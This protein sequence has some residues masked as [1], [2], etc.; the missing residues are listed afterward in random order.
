MKQGSKPRPERSWVEICCFGC[1]CLQLFWPRVVM[2]KLLNINPRDSDYSA[3]TDDG[4]DIGSD[5]ETEEFF[6]CG[7]GIGSR[8]RGIREEDPQPDLNDC[9]PRLRRRNSETFRAQY[10]STKELRFVA[11]TIFSPFLINRICVGTWNVGG[12]VPPDDLDIDDWID[13]DEPADIYVFGF[14][15]IVPLN[16]GNIF[17]AEDNRPVP[18]WENIIRETLDRIQPAN[19]KVKCYSDPSSPTKFKP[20]DDVP[21]LEEEII[22]ESESDIGE[23]IYPLDEDPNGFDEV[24]NSSGKNSVLRS[25]GVS[26]FNDVVELDAPLEQGLQR[27]ISSSKSLNGLN[28]L[29]MEDFYEDAGD[30][31]RLQN[32]KFTRT[33]S[34][35]AENRKLTRMLSGT[36]R[37]GLSWPEPPLNFLPQNVLERP[38]SFKPRKS[39]RAIKSFKTYNSFKSINDMCHMVSAIALL[40]E[41]DLES[42]M[43][44]KRR[45]S[46]V[47]IVSKQ[48]V[49]IFLTIW[50]RR[51]LRRHIQNLKVSTVGVGVMGYIGNKGSISVSMSIYQTL[52]CFICTHLTSG[53]KD[54]DELKRNAD[55]HEI[56][57]RTRFHSLSAIGLPK[58]IHDHER[59]IWM[60]DLNY[61]INLPYDKVRDLISKEEWSKLIERD[62][63]VGEL[64][65]GHSFDGWSEGA[66][67]FAPTYK[68]ELNSEKYY[69]E[70]PKAGR[71][72]PAWCDRI[73][74]YGKGLR[75]LMYRR[76]ELKL[77]D[78]RPVTAIYMAEVEV[79]CPKKLQRALN[80][81]DAEIENEEV[82][83][84][85]IAY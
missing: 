83:A 81:T 30:S 17:G 69:G 74:S 57:R 77:S 76:T 28:C 16:A 65:K 41:L 35:I 46:Y 12:T 11:E 55:V 19:T 23:E 85:V 10:I 61:R 6:D 22:L 58:R 72:T 37:I 79:F 33:L 47:R 4:D 48:M 3:D 25:Y 70:D 26:Y 40:A 45:S 2:R 44:R 20:F 63:L 62:Q 21:N 78:H 84:E 5:S 64:Q 82:V 59:I 32:R 75:Q 51:S 68:Y 43:K 80:Y 13:I 9:L 38:G 27:Q 66:L 67:N 39:F 24:D 18:K 14:Q 53:E 73:L 52:F 71:R 1:S 7:N 49:G 54:G 56:L 15:E 42:L 50:V 34:G 31:I 60:G 29:Q 36:E 8:F